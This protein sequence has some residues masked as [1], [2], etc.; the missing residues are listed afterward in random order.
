MTFHCRKATYSLTITVINHF[1]FVVVGKKWKDAHTER[2]KQSK[3]KKHLSVI[4]GE[5]ECSHQHPSGD[6]KIQ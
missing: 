5:L 2:T 6:I 3:R 4:T 1:H